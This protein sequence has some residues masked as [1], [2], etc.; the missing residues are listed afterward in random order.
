[1]YL[2]ETQNGIDLNQNEMDCNAVQGLSGGDKTNSTSL[3]VK[4]LSVSYL[5][6]HIC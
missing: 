4:G 2:C 6:L 1:M 5:L 3:M